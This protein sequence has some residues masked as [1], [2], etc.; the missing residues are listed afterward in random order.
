MDY[1]EYVRYEWV[2]ARRAYAAICDYLAYFVLA[3][4]WFYLT[5]EPV[6]DKGVRMMEPRYGFVLI[7]IWLIYFPFIEAFDG[8]TLFKRV[9]KLRVVFE[10]QNQMDRVVSTFL[11]HLLDP[12]DL[13]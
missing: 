1:Q 2:L 6:G 13:F 8:H 9:F 12:I 11:R 5:S 3:A 4:A 10:G 7:F